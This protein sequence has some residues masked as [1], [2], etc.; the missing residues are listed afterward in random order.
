[1]GH[2]QEMALVC[3]V[4]EKECIVVGGERARVSLQVLFLIA[5]TK[6]KA[7]PVPEP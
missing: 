6:L 5:A 7:S 3:R 1:M 2:R 4:S